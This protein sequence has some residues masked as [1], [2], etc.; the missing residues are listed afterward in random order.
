MQ[1]MNDGRQAR[2]CESNLRIPGG[3]LA[4]VALLIGFISHAY[5]VFQY[6]LYLG[7]E[8]IYTEQAWSVIRE[9][10]L[11]PYTYFYDHAPAGWILQAA[12]TM[13]LPKQF[14][15]WGVA[16]NS[17]RVLMVFIHVLSVYLLF[18]VVVALSRS[19]SAAFLV[20]LVFSLSPLGLYYQRMVLLDNIMV[21]WLLLAIHLLTNNRGRLLPMLISGLAFGLALVTKENAL[22]FA[23]VI[24]YM[25]YLQ[26]KGTYRARFAFAGWMFAWGAVASVYPLYAVLKGELLPAGA[27][28]FTGRPQEHVSLI[29]TI[30]WQLGRSG[31]SV[32]DPGSR[33]WY[34]WNGFWWPK[35]SLILAGGAVA[36]L[37]CLGVGLAEHRREKGYLVAALL[38]LSFAFYLTR[39]S[40]MLAFYIVPLLPFLAMSIGM[41]VD[42][43]IRVTP[44]RM[45]SAAFVLVVLSFTGLYLSLSRDHYTLNL[46]QEQNQQLQFIR[47]NIPPDANI[48]IDDD[49]WVDLHERNDQWPVFPKA[50]SHWKVEDDPEIQVG[51]LGGDWRNIDYI[52]MSDDLIDTFNYNKEQFVLAAYQNSRVIAQFEKGDVMVQVRQV[53]K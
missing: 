15:T 16:I 35:D 40:E 36:V 10:R 20:C 39:G 8:G 6:P 27:L 18:K 7:D 2:N 25:L 32:F 11:S 33:F 49:L 41:L 22:F 46:T 24:G 1:L 3:Y 48:V 29:E 42:K 43:L 51:V 34:F 47:D 14:L 44:R 45:R 26:V 28:D 5:N 13:L 50:H 17:G 9:G 31:G 52:V 19:T 30:A 12:W 53:N 4:A 21:L 37:G 38:S 23:P